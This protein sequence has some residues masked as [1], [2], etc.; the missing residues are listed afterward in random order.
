MVQRFARTFQGTTRAKPKD[1]EEGA[2]EPCFRDDEENASKDDG[3]KKERVPVDYA[4]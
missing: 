2:Q 4:P 3:L 1:S